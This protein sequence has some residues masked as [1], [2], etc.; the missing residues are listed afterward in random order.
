MENILI[1]EYLEELANKSSAR[2]AGLNYVGLTEL[3]ERKNIPIKMH[4]FPSKFSGALGG[5]HPLGVFLNYDR[6]KYLSG[7]SQYHII[8]HEIG[9]YLKIRML[10]EDVINEHIKNL[11]TTGDFVAHLI[12]EEKF[13]ERFAKL[14]FKR[15]NGITDYSECQLNFNDSSFISGTMG[16]AKYLYINLKESGLTFF[17]FT[18]DMV[19][20]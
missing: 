17:E 14:Y 10:G 7:V 16:Y 2:D 20:I 18:K 3:I 15:L 13:A 19:K 11:A 5:A 6:I 9:H 1:K 4:S 12:E 8:L